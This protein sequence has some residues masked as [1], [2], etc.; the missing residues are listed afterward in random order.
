MRVSTAFSVLACWL[1]TACVTTP[2]PRVTIGARTDTDATG[3]EK[4]KPL[5]VGSLVYPREAALARVEGTVFARLLLDETGQVRRVVIVR[6]DFKVGGIPDANGNIKTIAD[7]FDP[8]TI[9]FLMN[10][11]Y[12]PMMKDGKPY[13]AWV[14]QPIEYRLDK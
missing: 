2:P 7:L 13:S 12:T 5:K 3:F 6:R 14:E 4:S 11:R 8:P 10:S 1:L 9:A